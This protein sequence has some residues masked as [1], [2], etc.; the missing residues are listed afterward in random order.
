MLALSV[1]KG[2]HV[3]YSNGFDVPIPAGCHQ[4]SV[5]CR[6]SLQPPFDLQ[7]N[8]QQNTRNGEHLLATL[9]VVLVGVLPFQ[10]A[11]EAEGVSVTGAERTYT[12]PIRT[13][14]ILLISRFSFKG[15][16]YGN[17]PCTRPARIRDQ[18]VCTC[19]QAVHGRR[20]RPT[21]LGMDDSCV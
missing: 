12:H 9:L 19:H 14:S 7:P 1:F 13:S 10:V 16:V 3:I 5:R 21:R 8:M 18:A 6:L 2:Q 20:R 15:T 4:A 11:T 17:V